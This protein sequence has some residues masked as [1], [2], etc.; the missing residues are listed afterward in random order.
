MGFNSAFKGLNF[1]TSLQ[2]PV[3]SACELRAVGKRVTFICVECAVKGREAASSRVSCLAENKAKHCVC[4]AA[5]E[6][7]TSDWTPNTATPLSK[8]GFIRWCLNWLRVV[9]KLF[10]SAS[11]TPKEDALRVQ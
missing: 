8:R 2:F 9:H 6:G 4:R 11:C 7:T 3:I 10:S 1:S 5:A